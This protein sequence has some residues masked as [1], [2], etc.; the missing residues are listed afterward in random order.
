[1]RNT[2]MPHICVY[3]TGRSVFD[4]NG[5]LVGDLHSAFAAQEYGAA[6]NAGDIE[7]QPR[8]EAEGA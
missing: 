3:A 1:M 7:M 8:R 5:N 6:V 2:L 4:H